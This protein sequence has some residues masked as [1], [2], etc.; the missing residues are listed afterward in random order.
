[1]EGYPAKKSSH[2]AQVCTVENRNLKIV[3][4]IKLFFFLLSIIIADKEQKKAH[5]VVKKKIPISHR[6]AKGH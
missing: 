3:N 1:M 6:W 5:A 2:F 4:E